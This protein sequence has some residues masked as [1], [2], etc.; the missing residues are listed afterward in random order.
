MEL[1]HGLSPRHL[2]TIRGILAP[3]ASRITHVSLFG[4]RAMGN[5]RV[6]SDIDLVLYGDLEEASINRLW[7][8]FDESSL[9]FA[10]DVKGYG[11]IEYAPLKEHI[12]RV[13][14]VLFTQRELREYVAKVE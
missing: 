12:D 6:N 4:S 11:L 7:T 1:D 2:K 8:L 3:F 13:G 9:P 14:K 10:V 5:Y